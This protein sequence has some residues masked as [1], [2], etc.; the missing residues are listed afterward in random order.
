MLLQICMVNEQVLNSVTYQ[1]KKRLLLQQILGLG[2]EERLLVSYLSLL[3]TYVR[4]F[5]FNDNIQTTH[6]Y[7]SF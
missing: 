4:H 1:C 2:Y 5:S 6:I 7:P 3:P